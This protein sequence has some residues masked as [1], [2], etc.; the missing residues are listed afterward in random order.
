MWSQPAPPLHRGGDRSRESEPL[1]VT[2]DTRLVPPRP[3]PG[4]YPAHGRPGAPPD[5]GA[6]GDLARARIQPHCLRCPPSPSTSLEAPKDP[7]QLLAHSRCSIS[8]GWY[9]LKGAENFGD[10]ADTPGRRRGV[11]GQCGTRT[12]L[13]S[14]GL[15]PDQPQ[16]SPGCRCLRA[17][18]TPLACW[19]GSLAV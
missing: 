15:A 18:A 2:Q 7:A 1:D 10:M 6:W 8:A 13:R 3:T 19:K 14:R 5:P 4:P 9:E 16:L 12:D 11:A 17:G